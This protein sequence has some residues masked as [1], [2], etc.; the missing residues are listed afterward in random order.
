MTLEE[1]KRIGEKYGLEF[2]DYDNCFY[3][4]GYAASYNSLY[5]VTDFKGAETGGLGG[6]FCECIISNIDHSIYPTSRYSSLEPKG[7]E[8][9][10]KLFFRNY[11]KAQMKLKTMELEKDFEND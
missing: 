8:E 5:L 4:K 2:C 7:F 10:L 9:L 3:L 11:K 1:Y 6:V